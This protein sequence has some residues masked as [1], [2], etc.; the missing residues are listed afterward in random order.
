M[1]KVI[2]IF[3]RRRVLLSWMFGLVF[4]LFS[5]PPSSV[6]SRTALLFLILGIEIAFVG[7]GMRIWASGY[8]Y[9][10][11]CLAVSGPFSYTRNPLYVG[12]F[13]IGLGFCLATAQP[14]FLTT[15]LLFFIF[16]FISTIMNEERVL[17]EKFGAEFIQYKEKVPAFIPSMAPYDSPVFCKFS[18]RQVLH[19][20]E[21]L[22]IIGVVVV[23]LYLVIRFHLRY[24]TTFISLFK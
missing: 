3:S 2:A 13:L 4:V 20:R 14:L 6:S 1:R 24:N 16:V 7:E 18:W 17:S 9:K 12:S 11:E 8:L 22:S 5:T 23:A 10:D 19:N 21:Y 15:F